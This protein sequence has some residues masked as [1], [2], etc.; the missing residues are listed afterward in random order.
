METG[1]ELVNSEPTS[2]SNGWLLFLGVAGMACW[3]YKMFH[4]SEDTAAS[5]HLSFHWHPKN[6][7]SV[8]LPS[9]S[10]SSELSVGDRVLSGGCG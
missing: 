3:Y 5:N 4:A 7:Y 10:G 1:E 8:M 2:H 9:Y 6:F